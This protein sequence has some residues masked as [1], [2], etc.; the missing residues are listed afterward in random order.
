MKKLIIAFFLLL[1]A[2]TLVIGIT[3]CGNNAG[4]EH[5]LMLVGGREATCK[6]GNIAYYVCKD[7]NKWFYD[8]DGKTEITDKTEV[9]I[10]KNAEHSFDGE[11]CSVCGYHVPSEGLTYTAKGDCYE[12]SGIGTATDTVIYIAEEYNGSPVT[13]IGRQAFYNR[14]SLTSIEIP[15]SITSIGSYAF[16][17]CSSLTGIEIPDGVTSIGFEAF[18]WCTGLTSIVVPDS[19]TSFD[20]R[21]FYE[22][23]GLTSATIGNGVICISISAFYGC[24]NLTSITT[25]NRIATIDIAAFSGC[26][27]LTSIIIPEGVT[28]IG[29]RAFEGCE[30]LTIYCRAESQYEVWDKNWNASNCPVVWGYKG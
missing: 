8:K 24:E 5:N 23:S 25:G 9:V 28:Y 7:C 18:G 2:M 1:F 15:D 21:V 6:K 16:S 22:C 26:S 29:S 19:V 27:S 12:V 20:E 11:I 4:N 14:S 17:G 13:S 10:P 30:N 3:A